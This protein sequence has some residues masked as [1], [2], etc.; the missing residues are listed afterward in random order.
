MEGW[1]T[2][3][4]IACLRASLVEAHAV[5]ADELEAIKAEIDSLVID[6]NEFAE[7][8]PWPEP[9]TAVRFVFDESTPA[10]PK[11]QQPSSPPGNGAVSS[12][13][14]ARQISYMQATFEALAE[15]MARDPSIFVMGEGVGKR[16]GNFR[17]RPASMIFTA[18]R[19]CA[20]RRSANVAL[21][22]S[23]AAPP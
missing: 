23:A 4:P 14:T 13:D 6:A 17:R 21:S 9:D 7:K 5:P 19:G 3:C 1:K 15:E 18:R 16:G 2:R 8:S 11:R 12:P 20:T 10:S 22:A